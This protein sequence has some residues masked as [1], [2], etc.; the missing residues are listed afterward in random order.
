MFFFFLLRSLESSYQDPTLIHFCGC[1]VLMVCM[2]VVLENFGFGLRSREM[3]SVRC[4]SLRG[5]S[6]RGIGAWILRN[7]HAHLHCTNL[8]TPA[9]TT[10]YSSDSI[11]SRGAPSVLEYVS[12]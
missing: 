8:V 6:D 2:R 10:L 4:L 1:S 5:E 9:F 12:C 11:S 3:A 7:L